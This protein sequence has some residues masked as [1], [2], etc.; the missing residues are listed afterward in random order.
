MKTTKEIH[1]EQAVSEKQQ[2]ESEIVCDEVADVQ[3]EGEIRDEDAR[4]VAGGYPPFR[5][6]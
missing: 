6:F 5:K 4:N 3:Y 2:A 1:E